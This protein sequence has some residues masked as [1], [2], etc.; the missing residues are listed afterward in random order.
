MMPPTSIAVKVCGITSLEQAKKIAQLGV[1]AIGVIGVEKSARFITEQKRRE[2]F[3]SLEIFAP[4]LQRVWVV[5]DQKETSLSKGLSGI[6]IPS[7]VQLHGHESPDLCSKLKKKHP[8]TQWWKAIRIK[9]PTDIKSACSYLGVVDALLLDSWEHGQL[10][11]TGRRIPLEWL[12]EENLNQP[13]W[14]AGGISAEV[15]P[16]LLKQVKPWGIDASSCLETAP[17]I[18]DLK[19]VRALVN[20]I[21]TYI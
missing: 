7:V 11:G 8:D 10:G 21:N 14:L 6:G 13:W 17:G 20:A 1:N 2:L 18:K 12:T 5:A 16:E 3:S 19:K 4:D 9:S 15:I